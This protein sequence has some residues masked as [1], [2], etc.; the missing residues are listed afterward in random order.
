MS[1]N[2]LYPD[3]YVIWTVPVLTPE[4]L[5]P[6]KK[7]SSPRSHLLTSATVS[8]PVYTACTTSVAQNLSNMSRSSFEIDA[9][10]FHCVTE[11]AP[12]SSFLYVNRSP[13]RSSH[14]M[15]PHSSYPIYC[16]H[17]FKITEEKV[18]TL[19]H[20]YNWLDRTVFCPTVTFSYV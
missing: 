17:S 3:S 10:G 19:F 7:G 6:Y 14:F 11:I 8:I 4:D 15:Y 5:F 20:I 2:A 16:E 18:L 9:A 13:I 1:E 12:K